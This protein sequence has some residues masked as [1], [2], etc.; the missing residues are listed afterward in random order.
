MPII[1][2][3]VPGD[4]SIPGRLLYCGVFRGVR[5]SRNA[6]GEYRACTER[7]PQLPVRDCRLLFGSLDQPSSYCRG[8]KNTT[9]LGVPYHNL[10]YNGPQNPI[11][12]IK[13]PMSIEAERLEFP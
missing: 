7:R 9:I 1:P 12:I 4:H 13:A 3:P 10:W 6:A 2:G 5:V 8:L 11:L